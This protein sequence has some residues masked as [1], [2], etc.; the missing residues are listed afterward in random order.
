MNWT[1]PICQNC[2]ISRN[3]E[4]DPVR[5]VVGDPENCCDCGKGTNDGIYIRIDPRTVKFPTEERKNY[6]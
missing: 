1:Q 2:W 6:R 4:R 3:P 5:V